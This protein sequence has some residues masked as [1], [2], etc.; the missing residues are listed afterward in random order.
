MRYPAEYYQMVGSLGERFPQLRPAQIGGLALWVYGTLLAHSGCQNAVVSFLC[1]LGCWNSV[2]QHLREWLYDGAD[3]AAAC[4]TQ[5]EVEA[6]FA[7][8]LRWILSW[9]Q[10]DFLALAVDETAL[11]DRLAVLVVSVLY[12]G[13]ALPVAWCVLPAGQKEAWM[14]HILRLLT[15]LQPA[16]PE[17]LLVLV[18]VDRGLWSPKLWR[19]I[20][21]QHWHPLLRQQRSILFRPTGQPLQAAQHLVHGPGQAW[22]GTGTAFKDAPKRQDGTLLVVWVEGQAEPWVLLTDLPP[23]RVEP[24]WY[25]LRMW[26]ELGFRVLKRFGWQWQR[27]QRRDPSRVQ[28]HW[29]VLA[30]ASLWVVAYGTRAEDAERAGLDPATLEAPPTTLPLAPQPRRQSLFARGLAWF[31][32]QLR[33]HQLWLSL[34]LLPE[35]WPKRPQDLSVTYHAPPLSR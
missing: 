6:C 13:T 21:R 25:A 12:R 9:W 15:L 33:H 29:L 16:V 4:H 34:W 1:G 28:R 11:A 22:L 5:V 35:A 31:H 14:P 8:L 2:R 3:R 19:Q 26:I 17:S 27:S 18:L 23:L 24:A 20:R 32:Y 30:V 7:P 10:A